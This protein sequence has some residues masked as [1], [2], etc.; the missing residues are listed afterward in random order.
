M[1]EKE[2]TWSIGTPARVKTTPCND[3]NDAC[4]IAAERARKEERRIDVY[5]DGFLYRY[6]DESG[7]HWD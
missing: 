5:R 6:Y 3:E 1:S 7:L 4:A 2:F